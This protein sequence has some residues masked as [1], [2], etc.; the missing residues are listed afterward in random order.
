VI[1]DSGT[2]FQYTASFDHNMIADNDI[3]LDHDSVGDGGVISD[4]AN[5]DRTMG[6]NGRIAADNCLGQIHANRIS[7]RSMEPNLFDSLGVAPQS[8]ILT[9]SSLLRR[10][11][12]HAL[13]ESKIF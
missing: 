4:V 10:L 13:I 5:T 9:G 1:S 3:V 8:A 11:I 2:V 6:S 7:L 12:R